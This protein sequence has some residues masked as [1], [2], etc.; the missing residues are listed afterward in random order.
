LLLPEKQ[1][2]MIIGKVVMAQKKRFL[3]KTD[4]GGDRVV[5]MMLGGQQP[6]IF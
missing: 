5:D 4:F 1:Y 3:L 6:R 2:L